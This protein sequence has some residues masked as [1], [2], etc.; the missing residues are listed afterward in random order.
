MDSMSLLPSSF[1]LLSTYIH[2]SLGSVLNLTTSLRRI[3]HQ[4]RTRHPP[5]NSR[6]RPRPRRLGKSNPP[7]PLRQ[8]RRR[9]RAPD[10]LLAPCSPTT[11]LHSHSHWISRRRP[12]PLGPW[13]RLPH[14]RRLWGGDIALAGGLWAGHVAAVQGGWDSWCGCGEEG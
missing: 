12:A 11:P 9:R 10:S 4:P 6:H 7:S 13:C 5:P 2:P 3:Q 8:T 14:H 1:S